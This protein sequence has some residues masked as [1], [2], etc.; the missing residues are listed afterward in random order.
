MENLTLTGIITHF[1]KK[2]KYS[3]RV[4]DLQE[5]DIQRIILDCSNER[6][7]ISFLAKSNDLL[8][9]CRIGTEVIV[10]VNLKGN[11]WMYKNETYS[12]NEFHCKTLKIIRNIKINYPILYKDNSYEINHYY[13]NNNLQLKLVNVN[14]KE[15]LILSLNHTFPNKN[16]NKDHILFNKNID[17]ELLK[18]LEFQG[19]LSIGSQITSNQLSG[20]ICK[21]LILDY[22]LKIDLD[23]KIETYLN[24][25]KEDYNTLNYYIDVINSKPIEKLNFSNYNENLKINEQSTLFWKQNVS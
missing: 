19:I 9:H 22:I 16:I 13:F 15:E 17:L 24:S 6:Y 8:K 20:W 5:F 18:T 3:Q 1:Y 7:T 2:K 4:N 14:S 25:Q 21:F 12:A 11:V 10:G 23:K